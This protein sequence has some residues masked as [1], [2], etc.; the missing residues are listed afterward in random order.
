MQSTV[1]VFNQRAHTQ[2]L[3]HG[4]AHAHTRTRTQSKDTEPE[5]GGTMKTNNNHNH[6]SNNDNINKCM[7]HIVTLTQIFN[8][9]S[10]F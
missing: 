5:K 6:N 10:D 1:F 2:I 7:N 9:I 4:N 8:T 3:R